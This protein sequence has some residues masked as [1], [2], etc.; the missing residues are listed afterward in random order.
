MSEHE[1]VPATTQ[2]I[3]A[4]MLDSLFDIDEKASDDETELLTHTL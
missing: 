2:V 1:P 4:N 3:E